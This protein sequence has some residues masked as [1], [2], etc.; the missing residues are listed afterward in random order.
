M[1]NWIKGQMIN[2]LF[3]SFIFLF[4]YPAIVIT[5][6]LGTSTEQLKYNLFAEYFI[7]ILGLFARHIMTWKKFKFI[8]ILTGLISIILII[9][10]IAQNYS[11]NNIGVYIIV[12]FIFFLLGL[13]V[14]Y[15]RN[16][17]NSI[18]NV[19][20]MGALFL[21][22]ELLLV[23]NLTQLKEFKKIFFIVTLIFTVISMFMKILEN[24]N[25]IFINRK[26][27]NKN[28]QS[29]IKKFS[30]LTLIFL[31]CLIIL[32][33]NVKS[34]LFLLFNVLGRMASYLYKL[35]VY[36]IKLLLRSEPA[37]AKEYY[38][39]IPFDAR[40]DIYPFVIFLFS[41][42]VI[43]ALLMTAYILIP[44]AFKNI[45]ANFLKFL[46]Y[47]L[48]P[49]INNLMKENYEYFDKIEN[50][51]KVKK[52][53]KK[54]NPGKNN[55]NT[56]EKIYLEKD[57]VKKIRLFYQIVLEVLKYNQLKIKNSDTTEEILKKTNYK[58]GC[59][60]SFYTITKIYNNVR[61]G[62]KLPR[63]EDVNKMKETS[64]SFLEFLNFQ[65]KK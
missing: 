13:S 20:I 51:T 53:N 16:L 10:C 62:N 61:Y 2:L 47:L 48:K 12:N 57:P 4:L 27:E 43:F 19:I 11:E 8:K 44:L 55:S 5:V 25:T 49:R 14:C 58:Y 3:L 36:I 31:F 6:R 50:V 52:H 40:P 46:K 22:V 63:S 23:N 29:Q 18:N 34:I 37:Q 42:V 59:H 28:V 39:F 56:I 15:L 17:S 60:N 54:H 35:L 26:V 32:F 45:K 7:S 64:E 41:F 24:F 30:Y 1:N 38:G 21:F 33:I 9:W 65:Y